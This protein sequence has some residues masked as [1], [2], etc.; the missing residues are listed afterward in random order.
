MYQT[1][2]GDVLFRYLGSQSLGG[3]DEGVTQWLV[4]SSKNLHD[5]RGYGI[6]YRSRASDVVGSLP[7]VLGYCI[8]FGSTP[9]VAGYGWSDP[10]GYHDPFTLNGNVHIV[11]EQGDGAH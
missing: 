7:G 5:C 4:G 1:N 11:A 6:D 10:G 8:P 3:P 9:D 2:G